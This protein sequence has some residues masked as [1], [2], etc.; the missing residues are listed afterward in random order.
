MRE[1]AGEPEELELEGEHERVEG[2]LS[3]KPR[4]DGVEEVEEAGQG[5]ER[6]RVRVP[7]EEEAQHGLQADVADRKPVAVGAAQVVGADEID[8]GDGV[9]LAPPLVQHRLDVAE[10]LETPP[11]AR[12][13]LACAFRD[14]SGA[15][16]L[17][18]EEMEHA[19]GL[20]VANRPQ[21][22]GL[23]LPRARHAWPV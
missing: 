11:E 1:V 12:F 22:D 23:G 6:A 4:L 14:R 2:G 16:P 8:A 13:R 18:R 9:E 21:D 15:A 17:E 3:G 5:V 10:R 19:V 20:A 7:L